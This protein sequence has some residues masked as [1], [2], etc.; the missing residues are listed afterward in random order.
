MEP[1]FVIDFPKFGILNKANVIWLGEEM[2]MM[3]A[4][5][6][7]HNFEILLDEESRL[8]YILDSNF[9]RFLLG[10]KSRYHGKKFLDAIDPVNREELFKLQD[11]LTLK[12]F[13]ESTIRTY[14]GEFS[15]LL[16]VL[17]DY[18]VQNLTEEKIRSYF[19]YCHKELTLSE[20][21]IHSRMNAIKF[22]FEKVLGR[23]KFFVDI[24]RPKKA[25]IL[26]KA[27]NEKDI[28]KL[29]DVTSNIKH[30]LILKLCYG[31]GLRVS[32]I[33]NLKVEDV[34]GVKLKVFIQRSKGKKDRYVNLPE[35]ILGEL[36]EYYKAFRP[37]Y[38]LFEGESGGQYSKRS[39]QA[40]FKQAMA[41]AKITKKVGIHSLRH[42]YATHL[43]EYGTDI[44][45][46]QK[47]LGHNSIKTTL[48]YTEVTD[49]NISNVV[50]PLDRMNKK[51]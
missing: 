6:I 25:S 12:S 35:S 18:P 1:A 38:Y 2:F 19:L 15:Q 17:G 43:L 51:I 46:I 47:L 42:S 27:L 26:P 24:P 50:S 28:Q 33:I 34:D 21:Q 40:V 29:F 23:T 44:S 39:A 32:E 31:T 16:N 10:F 8:Y 48:I 30:L 37:K 13:T 41:K 4:C 3:P 9:A 22:Y 11:L 7:K 36:R 45:L 14:S 49:K 5:L 20:N